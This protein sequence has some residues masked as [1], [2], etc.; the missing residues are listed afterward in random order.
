MFGEHGG[1]PLTMFLLP[2]GEPF[3][4]GTYF[5]PR[6]GHGRPSFRRVLH[7]LA[8][9]YR[10][11]REEVVGQATKLV[12][13]LVQLEGRGAGSEATSRIPADLVRRVAE[14]LGSRM[15][16]REGGFEG[17]PKFPNPTALGLFLRAYGRSGDVEAVRIAARD[18]VR[19]TFWP[20]LAASVVVLALG[21]PML[22]LFG[23]RGGDPDRPGKGDELDAL[24]WRAHRPGEPSWPSPFGAGRPGWHIE[25][26]AIARATV[27]V[28]TAKS[29]HGCITSACGASA[30]HCVKAL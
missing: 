28:R 13:A 29:M 25:C 12:E 24:L 4:G 23:E 6:D 19:W 1:W 5:P 26:A 10:Q 7:A 21:W 3:F 8:Q 2:T 15:D 17:A 22:R 27:V 11:D 16:A 20:S 30:A 14:R 18:A 9:A